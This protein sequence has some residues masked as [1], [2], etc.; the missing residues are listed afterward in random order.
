MKTKA[1]GGIAIRVL[2]LL[3]SLFLF[4]YASA[5]SLQISDHLDNKSNYSVKYA[6]F[7]T[8]AVKSTTTWTVD[9]SGSA[10]FTRI[11]D[12]L[13]ASNPGDNIEVR[14]GN[15]S[16]NVNIDKQLVL[17]GIDTGAGKPVVDA[18]GS[19]SVITISANDCVVDGFYVTG[20]GS[21]WSYAGI[22]IRSENNKIIN[23]TCSYNNNGIFFEEPYGATTQYA[24]TMR[25]VYTYTV[26]TT[27]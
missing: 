13:N 1:F 17:R 15:Y 18:G 8:G 16:E 25:K 5:G 10:D 24:I 2:V 11:Q 21:G 27:T 22:K 12:A 4:L 19:G 23:N 6:A 3:S 7:D 26:R 9:D 20:S 14:S